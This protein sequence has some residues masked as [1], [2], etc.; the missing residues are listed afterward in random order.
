MGQCQLFVAKLNKR[1]KETGW[2][3][4]LPKEAEWEYACRGGPMAD[5]ADSA[6][7]F[8]FAK[9]TNT[10]L[11]DQANFGADKG[12]NRTCKVGSYQPNRLGLFD[13]HGNVWEWCE[14]TDRSATRCARLTRGGSWPNRLR[15]LQGGVSTS[16][17][18]S[19]PPALGLR[20]ARVP[21]GAPSPE[22]KTP[23]LA[24]APFTDADVQRIAALPAEQQVEEVRK[25]LMR[26]NP[27]FDG[28]VEH[29]IED[30]VVT[31]FRIVTDKVTD[32]APIRVFNALRV[33]DCSGT[34]TDES[35]GQ[36]ADLTPLKGMNL[37][38]LTHLNLTNTKVSDAGL[39]HFKDCK[40]LTYLDLWQ[41]EGERRGPG[42]LQGL[43]EPDGP[44]PG[45]HAGERRG[46][47]PLQGLQ[48]PD[49]PQP[50]R[51]EGERRGPGP[52]QGLQEPDVPLPG[53]HAGGRRGPGPLQGHASDGLWIDD[54]G[55]TDLTPL[56]GMPL[57]EIRLTPKN[58]TRGLDILRDMKS[59]KTI[60]IGGTKPG[61]RRS[62][63]SATTRGSSASPRSPTPTSSASPPCRPTQQVEEVRKE[64][65]R[66]NPGFDGKVEHKIED[67][68]VTGLQF[69]TDEVDNIAPVRALKGLTSLDCSGA[70]M[71]KG[72][73]S[74]L[75]PLK[76]LPLTSLEVGY[77]RIRDLTPLKGMRLTYLVVYICPNVSD[78]S[79]LEGMPLSRLSIGATSVRDLSPLKGM[80]LT[81]LNIWTCPI[82]DLEPLKGMP[83]NYLNIDHTDITDLKPLQ[84]MELE[85][86]H[87]TPKNITQGLEIL[88][89]MKSLTTIGTSTQPFPAAEFW[90]RYDKGEFTK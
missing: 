36:L 27:G 69:H 52:L 6:F 74:D 56:Q 37:A 84:G 71:K 13:M 67:G 8:Y 86:I 73:L 65:M 61:R 43:Q 46:P 35:N 12:L 40:N 5:K 90:Q 30:G 60:G 31:E 89:N 66:R 41:H 45:R 7:D 83:I 79:P 25:E 11:P 20:L 70:F 42:P 53:Q 80:K 23:P 55:I 64:L 87:L 82:P 21:S 26:R 57:E 59:L 34:C 28:K 58:I 76:D 4:R 78:L 51:H 10:L 54:T 22:A 47:G 9:P 16:A 85:E 49:G 75:S 77:N 3:Y 14:D 88:R 29:K 38:A 32:I 72:K 39:A 33:L 17:P 48:E 44:R 2:V 19:A 1:E 81:W 15:A 63:G 68:V 50:G 62:S 24:V 18:P